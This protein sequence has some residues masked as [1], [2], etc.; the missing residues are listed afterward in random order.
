MEAWGQ[1]D[2]GVP[3]SK[4]TAIA[5]TCAAETLNRVADRAIQMWGGAGAWRDL[6]V[7]KIAREMRPFRTY[8]GP[9]HAH[10]WAAARRAVRE[11]TATAR[12]VGG[13]A[14]TLAPQ[15]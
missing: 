11:I 7:A 3:A 10:R 14:V 5:K 4:A 1:L 6:P 9:S 13:L 2:V 8:D 15:S 12:A